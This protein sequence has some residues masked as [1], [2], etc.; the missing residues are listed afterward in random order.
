MRNCGVR[1]LKGL[2][3]HAN[4]Q[5]LRVIDCRHLRDMTLGDLPRLRIL[6]LMNARVGSKV[7]ESAS[8]MTELRV[9][10]LSGC[11]RVTDLDMRQ[12]RKLE[13]LDLSKT[14]IG[15]GKLSSLRSAATLRRIDMANCG[16]LPDDTADALS[17]LPKLRHL[18][19]MGTKFSKD[20]IRQIIAIRARPQVRVFMDDPPRLR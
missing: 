15:R 9:L 4:I 8:Q 3:Q 6:E 14:G 7:A 11:P 20:A 12:L 2:K 13:T 16:E 5:E 17:K 10:S 19:V 1:I 18:D